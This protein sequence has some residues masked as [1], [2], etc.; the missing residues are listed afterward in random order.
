MSRRVLRL[1]ESECR[2]TPVRLEAATPS[3]CRP[4][5]G[6]GWL[7]SG[8]WEGVGVRPFLPP[9]NCPQ[10]APWCSRLAR[11]WLR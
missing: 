2:N 8:A 11:G 5:L 7:A 4:L 6:W 1:I 9:A 3:L 10:F